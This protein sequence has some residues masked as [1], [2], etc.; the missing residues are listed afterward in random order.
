M[1][2]KRKSL[3]EDA[4][5]HN[6]NA[7]CDELLWF[8]ENAIFAIS[9]KFKETTKKTLGEEIKGFPVIVSSIPI[10][11]LAIPSSLSM[12]L[13][14]NLTTWCDTNILAKIIYSPIKFIDGEIKGKKIIDLYMNF[15]DDEF[16]E[17]SKHYQI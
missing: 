12:D 7:I 4:I 2:K 9:R 3:L 13:D 16:V 8:N 5:N 11:E 6:L 14:G 1:Y 10:E 17:S 15:E